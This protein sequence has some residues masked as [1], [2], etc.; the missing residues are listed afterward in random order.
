MIESGRAH[1]EEVGES[2]AH[3]WRNATRF[4]LRMIGAGALCCLHGLMPGL[5]S[6]TASSSVKQLYREMNGRGRATDFDWVI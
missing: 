4:G 2:Y 1:L 6:K 3:H 5:F